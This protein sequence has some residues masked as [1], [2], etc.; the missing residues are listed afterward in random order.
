MTAL[1]AAI[2]TRAPA[3]PRHA[4]P[5]LAVLGALLSKDPA[6]RPD[7]LAT[8]RALAACRAGQTGS[9]NPASGLRPPPAGTG[10]APGLAYPPTQAAGPEDSR[11]THFRDTLTG[12]GRPWSGGQGTFAAAGAFAPPPPFT[13]HPSFPDV[14]DAHAARADATRRRRQAPLRAPEGYGAGRGPW[15]SWRPPRRPPPFSAPFLPCA[16]AGASHQAPARSG[17]GSTAGL[18]ASTP[19]LARAPASPGTAASPA[20]PT[21]ATAS[22]TA[23]LADPYGTGV[24]SL[25]F[26]PGSTLAEGNADGSTY[27]RNAGTK[28]VIATVTDPDSKGAASV[29]FESDGILATGDANGNTYLWRISSGKS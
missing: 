12:Q 1:I 21:S 28:S 23:T 25:A 10:A 11:G 13:G 26:G 6:H 17:A 22:L 7:A 15:S 16:A 8:A 24:A 19:A 4:G 29:A 18:H 27:L 9:S 5:L 20:L 2:L 3:T 14:R